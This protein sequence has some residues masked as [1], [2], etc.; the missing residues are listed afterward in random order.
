[1]LPRS[2]LSNSKGGSVPGGGV[3]L[4]R[5][6]EGY[7][8][9]IV[10]RGARLCCENDPPMPPAVP[11]AATCSRTPMPSA[12]ESVSSLVCIVGVLTVSTL[13]LGGQYRGAVQHA[14]RSS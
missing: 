11:Q 14:S 8:R 10:E 9:P 13:V 3:P 7:G 5:D 12:G 1:M 4:L 6:P 2:H